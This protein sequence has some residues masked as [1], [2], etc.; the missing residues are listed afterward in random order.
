MGPRFRFEGFAE[1]SP[2]GPVDAV[3]IAIAI[4]VSCFNDQPIPS[5]LPTGP[6]KIATAGRPATFTKRSPANRLTLVTMERSGVRG[7]IEAITRVAA[8]PH[9]ARKSPTA[10]SQARGRL[11]RAH[12][13]PFSWPSGYA[14]DPIGLARVFEDA[15]EFGRKVGPVGLD[16][17]GGTGNQFAPGEA[18]AVRIGGVRPVAPGS[19]YQ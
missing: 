5:G 6:P 17:D 19:R 11:C 2:H 13:D 7:G 8:A 10:R 9:P 16:R 12:G 15:L 4:L 3:T 18:V 1:G 14:G